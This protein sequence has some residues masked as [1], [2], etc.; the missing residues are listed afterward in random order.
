MSSRY[1]R[2]LLPISSAKEIFSISCRA[3][4]SGACAGSTEVTR[5]PRAGPL[6]L[7]KISPSRLA[8]YSMRVVLP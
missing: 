8:T 2:T 4:A 3:V 5:W 6:T 7:T 1:S